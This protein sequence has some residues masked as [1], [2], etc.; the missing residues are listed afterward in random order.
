MNSPEKIRLQEMKSRIEQIE[1][2]AW[3]LND[4]GQ[5]IPVIEQNVQNFLDTVFVL[6]FG[7]SDIAEIDAA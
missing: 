4:I 1:K 6:K 5:G 2:L 3:E 7:I